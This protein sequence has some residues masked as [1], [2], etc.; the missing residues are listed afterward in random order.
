MSV[1]IIDRRETW[2]FPAVTKAYREGRTDWVEV[3]EKLYDYCLG[4]LPPIYFRG[5]FFVSEPAAHTEAGEPVY[6]AVAVVNGRYFMRDV[7]RSQGEA[8]VA[9]LR[10]ALS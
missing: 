10:E 8:A 3:N 5:G 4:V 7:S 9:E 1:N 2:P 6:T